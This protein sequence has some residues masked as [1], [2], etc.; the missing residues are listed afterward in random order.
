MNPEHDGTYGRM[1]SVDASSHTPRIFCKK[2]GG[3]CE[4]RISFVQGND[5]KIENITT[6]DRIITKNIDKQKIDS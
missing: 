6:I 1:L 5:D 2:I 4:K 3:F